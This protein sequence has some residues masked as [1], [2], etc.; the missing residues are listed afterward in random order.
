LST[1]EVP[2][3]AAFKIVHR[4]WLFPMER[5]R[6][7]KNLALSS[8]HRHAEDFLKPSYDFF[9][10]KGSGMRFRGIRH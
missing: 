7:G 2:D 4:V 6:S 1:Q 9:G 5:A 10:I 8:S 3:F